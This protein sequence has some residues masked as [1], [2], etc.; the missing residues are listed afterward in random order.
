M[1]PNVTEFVRNCIAFLVK[2]A[3]SVV[4]HNISHI[5][6]QPIK[7]CQYM[8]NITKMTVIS[9]TNTAPGNIRSLKQFL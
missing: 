1:M 2:N 4:S 8:G 5:E 7:S 3:S 6:K 9:I